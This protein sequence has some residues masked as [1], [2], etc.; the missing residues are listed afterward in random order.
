MIDLTILHGRYE[1][2][3]YIYNLL[4]NKT[5]KTAQEYETLA[6][7]Y[8]LRYINYPIFIEALTSGKPIEEV[9]DFLTKQTT[10]G[11]SED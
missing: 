6:K 5:I 1:S 7:K 10:E 2:A 3:L 9:P 8:S 4:S 11:D